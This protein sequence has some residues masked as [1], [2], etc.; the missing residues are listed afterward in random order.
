MCPIRKNFARRTP[1]TKPIK[2]LMNYPKEQLRVIKVLPLSP[3]F[4]FKMSK[5]DLM[6][7]DGIPKYLY[8]VQSQQGK[9]N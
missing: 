2:E 6:V 7:Y 5:H 3:E 4:G 8:M 1:N 9:I